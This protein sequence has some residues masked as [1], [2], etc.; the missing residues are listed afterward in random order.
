[1]TVER[2]EQLAT[3]QAELLKLLSQPSSLDTVCASLASADGFQ[4]Y[5]EYVSTF[6]PRMV[7][8]A[9]ALVKRWGVRKP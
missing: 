5:R 8:V 2:D 4:T 6:E 1:M 7:E 9:V 3:Y